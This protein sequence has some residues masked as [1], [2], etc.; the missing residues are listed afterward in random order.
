M[1]T[2]KLA[3]MPYA[4]ATVCEENGAYILISYTTPVAY[5]TNT[6]WLV[7][8]GLYSMTTR[9]HIR[10]FLK[11]HCD[12]Y[13]SFDSIRQMIADHY[14]MNLDTGEVMPIGELDA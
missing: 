10:A 7:V 13:I 6:R 8:N 11:E 2:S 14:A 12:A 4:Q 3:T 5:I 9:R 1:K